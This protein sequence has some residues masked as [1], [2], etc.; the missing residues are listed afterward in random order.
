MEFHGLSAYIIPSQD[1][2]QSEYIADCDARRRFISKF[3][4]SAGVA[5][6]TLEHA[7]LW[8]DGRYFLQAEQELDSNWQLMKSG[9]TGVP[10]K[11][12]WLKSV[13]PKG[14][15]VWMQP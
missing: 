13:L 4:G 7:A 9:L 3:T 15:V 14:S 8:T 11:E 1:A 6:V 10:T 2:H 5:V 12:E